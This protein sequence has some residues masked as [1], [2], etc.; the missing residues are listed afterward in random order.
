MYIQEL[1]YREALIREETW[2][3]GNSGACGEKSRYI[4][5]LL[6]P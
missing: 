4:S 1:R 6:P 2:E 5:C 3:E